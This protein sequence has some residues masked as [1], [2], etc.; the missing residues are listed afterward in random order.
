MRIKDIPWWNRPDFKLKRDGVESLDEAE[1]LAIILW[2]GN[3]GESALEL[4]NKLLNV[5]NLNHLDELS[6]DELKKECNGDG[7]KAIKIMSLIELVKG[8]YNNSCFNEE[9]IRRSL[10]SFN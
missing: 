5:Y 8:G 3:K 9:L 6:V 10:Y 7:V 1:L 4:A 2:Y